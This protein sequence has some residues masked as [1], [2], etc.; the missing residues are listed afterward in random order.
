M[1]PI[2]ESM[3][4]GTVFCSRKCMERERN[5]RRNER[6]LTPEEWADIW[7]Q[8]DE[9]PDPDADWRPIPGT[10]SCYEV[11]PGTDRHPAGRVRAF[12][13]ELGKWWEPLRVRLSRDWG[14]PEVQLVL[15]SKKPYKIHTLILTAFIGPRPPGLQARH[16][17][18]VKTNN[19]LSNL[20][21]GTSSEDSYDMVRNGNHNWARRIFCH[22][23]PEVELVQGPRQRYCPR[24]KAERQKRYMTTDRARQLKRE[25]KRRYRATEHGRQVGREYKRRYRQRLRGETI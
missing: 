8:V 4:R 1:A 20:C 19:R 5:R 7:R 23:H 13:P 2:P 24:C 15:P 16:L 17:D 14:Y 6:P 3:R 18:D 21:W 22:K 25:N 11:T 9:G 10:Y 12:I